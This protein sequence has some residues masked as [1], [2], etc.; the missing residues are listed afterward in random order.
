MARKSNRPPE[1]PA[2]T[3]PVDL[4]ELAIDSLTLALLRMAGRRQLADGR[5]RLVS[6]LHHDTLAL[7]N[8]EAQGLIKRLSPD[9][10]IELTESG[11]R[12]GDYFAGVA[13]EAI[14]GACQDV[15]VE[16]GTRGGPGT[17]ADTASADHPHVTG[18]D[19]SSA[20]AA[21]PIFDPLEH[22]T[23]PDARAFRLRIQLKLGNRLPRCWR[24]IEIP[25]RRS[26]LDL[27]IAIQRIFNWYDEHIFHF[28]LTAYG[29]GLRAEQ[30]SF[31]DP[32]AECLAPPDTAVVEADKLLLG[33]VF[34]QTRSVLYL[35]DYGDGWEHEIALL[36][37]IEKTRLKNPRLT[38]GS[39]DA[40]PEDVGG[41]GGFEDFL[42][43]VADKDDPRYLDA[44]IWAESQMARPFDLG[45]KQRE[46]ASHFKRDRDRWQSALAQRMW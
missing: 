36:E 9:E 10:G 2:G 14:L 27:H 5:V 13:G 34:P 38:S 42:K 23:D 37:T 8:L 29:Q 40:P 45:E 24:E 30:S 25:A 11:Y 39:G 41:I 43:V 18:D 22:R 33:D 15:A 6:P 1:M 3:G 17:T 32:G 35:Y 44:L 7:D 31:M 16:A 26:F 20:E 28:K 21:R 19:R 4:T 12:L 46:L